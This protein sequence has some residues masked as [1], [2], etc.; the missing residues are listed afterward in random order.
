MTSNI[1]ALALAALWLGNE[2]GADA[3]AQL[4]DTCSGMVAPLLPQDSA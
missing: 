1:D 3:S 4:G 2:G